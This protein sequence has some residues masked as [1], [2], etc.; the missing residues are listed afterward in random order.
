MFDPLDHFGLPTDKHSRHWPELDPEP[1][2]ARATDA[3]TPAAA[4]GDDDRV[5]AATIPQT[6]DRVRDALHGVV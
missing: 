1:A 6:V 4:L 3:R 2:D 5:E